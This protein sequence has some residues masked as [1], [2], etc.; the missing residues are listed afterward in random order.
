MSEYQD[1]VLLDTP[2]SQS[3][4]ASFMD[5][6]ELQEKYRAFADLFYDRYVAINE[7]VR[8]S[9]EATE[10]K[11]RLAAVYAG[12]YRT[13]REISKLL[14]RKVFQTLADPF[15]PRESMEPVARRKGMRTDWFIAAVETF[16]DR[17]IDVEDLSKIVFAEEH[18]LKDREKIIHRTISVYANR[19]SYIDSKLGEK[20]LE[21]AYDAISLLGRPLRWTT[22]VCVEI[23]KT[24]QPED[25]DESLRP[26]DDELREVAKKLRQKELSAQQTLAGEAE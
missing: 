21:L 12:L 23:D 3:D 25:F 14:D 5:P 19:R 17:P 4:E 11:E 22:F 20:G 26:T 10:E 2:K 24:I 15:W 13:S 16:K 1:E 7:T 9:P 8:S 6:R 18:D